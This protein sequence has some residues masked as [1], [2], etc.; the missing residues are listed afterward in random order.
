MVNEF[1]SMRKKIATWSLVFISVLGCTTITSNFP[2]DVSSITLDN[3]VKI[4]LELNENIMAMMDPVVT[5]TITID[6]G[7]RQLEHRSDFDGYDYM[8]SLVK[9]QKDTIWILQER[10]G[11]QTFECSYSKKKAKFRSRYS[12]IIKGGHLDTLL[13]IKYEGFAFTIE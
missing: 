7:K 12:T 9:Q 1:H 8:I 6:Y 13:K 5:K 10:E 2:R 3:G 4:K 11:N